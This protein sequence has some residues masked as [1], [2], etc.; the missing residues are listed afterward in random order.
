MLLPCWL[1]VSWRAGILGIHLSH[2]ILCVCVSSHIP[3][4]LMRGL[5]GQ[6]LIKDPI[7]ELPASKSGWTVDGTVR[8]GCRVSFLLKFRKLESHRVAVCPKE[9]ISSM[10]LLVMRVLNQFDVVFEAPHGANF[11]SP[12]LSTL[13][14]LT[15]EQALFY[16]FIH[17]GIIPSLLS[18][19]PRLYRKPMLYKFA[20]RLAFT[21]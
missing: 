5:R 13:V 20:F 2:R 10:I 21:D 17:V 8:N 12:S 1:C 4:R 7:A 6:I 3:L 19:G 11:V 18:I 14:D 9:W 15:C 16:T